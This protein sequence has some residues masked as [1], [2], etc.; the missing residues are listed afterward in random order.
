[1]R[2]NYIRFMGPKEE[3]GV[4]VGR[5]FDS[6]FRE[7]INLKETESFTCMYYIYNSGDYRKFYISGIFLSVAD[8]R[9]L[10][11]CHS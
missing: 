2:K 6:S 3:D 5:W 4:L 11:S 7:L 10:A 8:N 9:V 1:M